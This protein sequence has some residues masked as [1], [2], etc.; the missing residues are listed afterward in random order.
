V[1]EDQSEPQILGYRGKDARRRRS[2]EQFG[3]AA[4]WTAGLYLFLLVA[5]TQSMFDHPQSNINFGAILGTIIIVFVPTAFVLSGIS[6]YR[7]RWNKWGIAGFAIN[8][9]AA[10]LIVLFVVG[11]SAGT[12]R[13]H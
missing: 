5:V 3:K 9:F 2:P 12:P 8:V 10:A 4:A 11:M 7:S 13:G 6:L 1:T